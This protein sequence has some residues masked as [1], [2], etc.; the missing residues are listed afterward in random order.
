LDEHGAAT[1]E[2]THKPISSLSDL[3]SLN[4]HHFAYVLALT[5]EEGIRS[6]GDLKS[7][8]FVAVVVWKV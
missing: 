6:W 8:M 4:L 3:F 5:G 2:L 7:V 1:E